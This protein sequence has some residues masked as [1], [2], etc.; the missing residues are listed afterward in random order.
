MGFLILPMAMVAIFLGLG[1]Q[2]MGFANA[3]PGAGPVGMSQQLAQTRAQQA[4]MLENACFEAAL[5]SPGTISSN[6]TVVVPSGVVLPTGAMCVTSSA[7]G[8]SRNVYSVVPGAPG[9][10][11]A[12]EHDTGHSAA[13]YEVTASGIA[14]NL[15][16]GTSIAVPAT[17]AKGSIVASILATP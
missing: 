5:T 14:T 16:D 6:L 1:M 10:A 13:W 17:F 3:V 11:A 8:G 9:A 4:E 2:A 12:I 7:G 15:A